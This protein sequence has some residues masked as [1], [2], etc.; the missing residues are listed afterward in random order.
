MKK[1]LRKS[2]GELPGYMIVIYLGIFSLLVLIL[3]S[4]GGI[5]VFDKY[6]TTNIIARKY[7][8]QMESYSHGYLTSD[9]AEKLKDDLQNQGLKNIDLSGSTMSEVENG[10]DIYLDI[11]YDQTYKKIEIQNYNIKVVTVTQRVEI[12]LSSTA[13]N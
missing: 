3:S 8:F 1:K 10:G 7:I 9:N 5:E 11:K 12:P 4:I 6:L 13:K 2:K